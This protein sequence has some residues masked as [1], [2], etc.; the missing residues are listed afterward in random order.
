MR[1]SGRASISLSDPQVS[2]G[3]AHYFSRKESGVSKMWLQFG[4]KEKAT[5]E[6]FAAAAPLAPTAN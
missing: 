2:Y 1:G 5:A 3:I 6:T 4:S